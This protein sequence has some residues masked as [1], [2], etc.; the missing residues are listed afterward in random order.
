MVLASLVVHIRGGM[1]SLGARV[2]N[3]VPTSGNWVQRPVGEGLV[4]RLSS[5]PVC[6]RAVADRSGVTDI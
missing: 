1:H 6:L 5:V 2:R 4:V 3:P